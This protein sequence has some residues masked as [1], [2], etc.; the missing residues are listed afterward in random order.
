MA[1]G[2]LEGQRRV[3]ERLHEPDVVQHRPDVEQLGVVA[4]AALVA[5]GRGPDVGAAAVVEQ[6][7]RARAI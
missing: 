4:D 1:A 3:V 6:R 7:R 2:V 5:E